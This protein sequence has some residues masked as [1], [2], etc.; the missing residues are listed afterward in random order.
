MRSTS[1]RA[2]LATLMLL[3]ACGGGAEFRVEDVSFAGPPGSG[4]PHLS[5]TAHG[6]AV[7][8]WF[9]PAAEGAHAL[10]LAVWSG[11]AWSEPRTIVAGTDF[12]VNWADFPS[13]IELADGS[14]VV[15][16]LEKVATGP[17]AY[18]VKLAVSRDRGNTWSEPVVPHR[19]AS[20]TEHG[21]VSL[22][23]WHGGAALV[24]LDGRAMG[25]PG[26][27]GAPGAEAGAMTVRF[28]TLAPDGA[29]GPD[30]LLDDRT[31][32]CC[33]TA[34]A[35]TAGGLVAAYRDRSEA[36]IRDIAIVR[37]ADGRWT[38]PAVVAPDGWHYPGCPVNGPQLSATGDTVALAW[39]TAPEQAP[40]VVVALSVDGGATFGAPTR[41]DDGRP[42]GRVDVELLADGSAVATWIELTGDVAEV[43]ARRVR[44]DGT[45]GPSWRVAPTTAERASGFPRMARV[46][47]ALFF[48]WT[49]TGSSGGVRVAA[50]RPAD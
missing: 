8:T 6:E 13:L 30:V 42:A 43:R 23:P 32:E 2:A 24:W 34:L 29:L 31:C 20:P 11:N 28:T 38:E 33:Q 25:E 19:D 14:W 48:A 41:V 16:W 40:R 45:R 36:E 22:V 37:F 35:R 7:L 1:R 49:L 27:H 12:F 21:F 9:E 4:E 10:K 47:N 18:H 5:A 44:R 17:Y 3:A 50:A 46:G 26:S 15:H 39:F